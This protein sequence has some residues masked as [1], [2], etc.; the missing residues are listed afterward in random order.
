MKNLFNIRFV[1][2][3]VFLAL[4]AGCAT[5]NLYQNKKAAK[6][7]AFMFRINDA[8]SSDP[9][10][11]E[12]LKELRPRLEDVGQDVFSQCKCADGKMREFI[13]VRGFFSSNDGDLAFLFSPAEMD[14]KKVIVVYLDSTIKVLSREEAAEERKKSYAYIENM[15]IK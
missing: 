12:T 14:A 15:H 4:L 2:A 1:S 10:F 13:Y 7:L 11:P 9:Q 6:R 8:I 3:V 5:T